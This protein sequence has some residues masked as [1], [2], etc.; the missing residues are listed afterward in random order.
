MSNTCSRTC[1]RSI[2]RS[3]LTTKPSMPS[4]LRCRRPKRANW[5]PSCPPLA[6]EQSAARSQAPP[7]SRAEP[8]RCGP[9][10]RC[11]RRRATSCRDRLRRVC[12]C[13]AA[14]TLPQRR[15][16]YSAAAAHSDATAARIR[17]ERNGRSPTQPRSQS[18]PSFCGLLFLSSHSHSLFY[19]PHPSLVLCCF[20]PS[21]D[22]TLSAKRESDIQGGR[23]AA[24]NTPAQLG[25]R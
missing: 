14:P 4:D 2:L 16:V 6:D 25:Y 11:D 18:C 9:I 20:P 5:R 12:D 10:P 7:L 15:R 19:S 22:I 23:K 3:S 1:R 17:R 24:Q 21:L 13:A 8:L